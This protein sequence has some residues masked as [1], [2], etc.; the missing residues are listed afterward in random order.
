MKWISVITLFL[1]IW[2]WGCEITQAAEPRLGSSFKQWCLLR[3]SLSDEAKK[4][5][6]VL[7]AQAGTSDCEQA[8]VDLSSRIRFDLRSN[9]IKDVSPLSGL[10]NLTV[11]LLTDN[12]IKDVSPL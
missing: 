6:E 3:E 12:Q 10:A 4:T 2:G 9:Q 5:V 1:S 7:L 11:L 8:S